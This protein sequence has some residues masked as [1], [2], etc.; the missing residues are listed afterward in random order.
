MDEIEMSPGIFSVLRLP[1]SSLTL[2][3]YHEDI[4]PTYPHTNLR[5]CNVLLGSCQGPGNKPESAVMAANK[6][7]QQY[8]FLNEPMGG[9]LAVS[10]VPRFDA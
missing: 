8:Y 5:C 4:A 3:V 9:W 10:R 7:W 1:M 6:S 2:E